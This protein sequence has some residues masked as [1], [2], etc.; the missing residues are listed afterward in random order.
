MSRP[1]TISSGKWTPDKPDP[2]VSTTAWKKKRKRYIRS[3][4]HCVI[5]R[6]IGIYKPVR[7]VDHVIPRMYGGDKWDDHNLQGLSQYYHSRKTRKENMAEG[8]LF[9]KTPEGLP[10]LQYGKYK[11]IRGGV[12]ILIIGASGSGKSTI[13]DHLPHSLY[14]VIHHIDQTS[15][16]RISAEIDSGGTHLIECVG[17]HYGLF[18]ILTEVD[19]SFFVIR[20]QRDDAMI[21]RARGIEES[22]WIESMRRQRLLPADMTIYNDGVTDPGVYANQIINQLNSYD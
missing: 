8:P 2:F 9:H 10:V 21:H 20:I 11:P 4:P 12:H 18:K 14:N 17:S 3:N 22:Q 6:R 19:R 16:S 7:I 1:W 15:W 13:I 5:S